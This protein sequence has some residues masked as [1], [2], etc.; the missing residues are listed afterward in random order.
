MGTPKLSKR[1]RA[2]RFA[3]DMLWFDMNSIEE[4]ERLTDSGLAVVTDGANIYT[5]TRP[6]GR[7]EGIPAGVKWVFGS[8]N[9]TYLYEMDILRYCNEE[10]LTDIRNHQW[11]ATSLTLYE[12]VPGCGKTRTIASVAVLGEVMILTNTR[13]TLEYLDPG[14]RHK[15]HVRTYGS[16]IKNP[17]VMS[18]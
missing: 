7:V 15:E 13:S 8:G 17:N 16:F 14:R 9:I 18:D 10:F 12:G 2:A 3:P 5:L 4:V 1:A 11:N 6:K